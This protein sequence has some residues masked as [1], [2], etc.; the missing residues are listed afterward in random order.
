MDDCVCVIPARAGSKRF[1]GKNWAEFCGKPIIHWPIIVT[2]ELFDDVYVSTDSE[3]IADIATG[4]FA[5]LL[6]RPPELLNDEATDIEVV[7]WIADQFKARYLCY[8]YPTAALV[9]MEQIVSGF[10]LLYHSHAPMMTCV[11]ET[12]TSSWHG[13]KVSRSDA[14]QFYWYDLDAVRDGRE[15]TSRAML[16]LD[17]L[18]C[19]DINTPYDLVVANLKAAVGPKVFP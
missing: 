1:P 5:H 7:Q 10:D 2:R 14:G 16:T 11:R 6:N 17:P 12:P 8:L 13:D 4:L 15:M 18:E 9:T 3:E 19:Q